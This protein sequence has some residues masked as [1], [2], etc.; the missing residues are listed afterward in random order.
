MKAIRN[1]REVRHKRI[2][3]RISGTSIRPRLFVFKSNQHIYAALIDDIK[4]KTIIASSDAILKDKK[5][6]KT[7]AAKLVG[8]E[9]GKKAKSAGVTRVVFDR[10][11]Y[12]YHGRVRALAEGARNSGLTF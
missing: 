3:S 5:I 2:R 12:K 4:N 6:N 10:G 1:K 7:D 9:L 8:E 11:G